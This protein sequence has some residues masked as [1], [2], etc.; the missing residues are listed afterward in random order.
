M[1]DPDKNQIPPLWTPLDPPQP[2]LSLSLS[3]LPEAEM[4]EWNI[5]QEAKISVAFQHHCLPI[6]QLP[7]SC[8]LLL[9]PP[10]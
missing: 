3:K 5:V 6:S 8:S 2:S 4:L 10:C 1:L 9:R 7:A